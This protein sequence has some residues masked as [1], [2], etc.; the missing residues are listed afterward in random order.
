MNNIILT[1]VGEVV[2]Q[3]PNDLETASS[4]LDL[5]EHAVKRAFADS[6]AA[7]LQNHINTIAVVRTFSE[8][9]AQLKSPFGDPVNLKSP[10]KGQN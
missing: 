9:G 6:E 4:P 8:S 3:V 7:N 5:M 2:E 10:Q 1:G